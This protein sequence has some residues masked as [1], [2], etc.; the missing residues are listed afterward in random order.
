MGIRSKSMKFNAI[1]ILFLITFSLLIPFLP[2]TFLPNQSGI[3]NDKI[4]ED[5]FILESLSTEDIIYSGV[6]NEISGYSHYERTGTINNLDSTKDLEFFSNNWN[7][8]YTNFTL[9]NITALDQYVLIQTFTGSD[10]FFANTNGSTYYMEFKVSNSSYIDK[11][12]LHAKGN[13]T[14]TSLSI[15][16]AT[17]DSG[18]KPDELIYKQEISTPSSPI[19]IGQWLSYDIPYVELDTSLTFN[20]TYYIAINSTTQLFGQGFLWEYY[21]DSKDGDQGAAFYSTDQSS[22]SLQN[23]DFISNV[24]IKPLSYYPDP[25]NIE[26]NINNMLVNFTEAP[27]LVKN[28]LNFSYFEVADGIDVGSFSTYYNVSPSD[29]N[30]YTQIDYYINLNELGAHYSQISLLNLTFGV[31]LNFTNVNLTQAN[32]SIYD[33][34]DFIVGTMIGGF[35]TTDPSNS[36]QIILDSSNISN[37]VNKSSFIKVSFNASSE[38]QNY[39]ICMHEISVSINYQPSYGNWA[40]NNGVGN[41]LPINSTHT[42]Y[43]ISTNWPVE[44]N[45][46]YDLNF[47]KN[48]QLIPEFEAN[49]SDELVDW[50]VTLSNFQFNEYASNKQINFTIPA[51]WNVSNLYNNSLVLNE[52][53][54][55]NQTSGLNKIVSIL[56][57]TNSTYRIN[58]KS[59]NY[60]QSI[61]IPATAEITSLVN[62]TVTLKNS[63]SGSNLGLLTFYLDTYYAYNKTASA[64]GALIS[65]EGWYINDPA[66]N[67]TVTCKWKNGTEVGVKR[68]YININ[69]PEGAVWGNGD[70]RNYIAKSI[71]GNSGS[72]NQDYL[73]LN[74]ETWDILSPNM[75]IENLTAYNYSKIIEQDFYGISLSLSDTPAMSFNVTDNFTISTIKIEAANPAPFFIGIW[76]STGSIDNPIPHKLLKYY[77]PNTFENNSDWRTFKLTENNSINI[78]SDLTINDGTYYTYFIGINATSGNWKGSQ[79]TYDGTDDGKDYSIDL[80]TSFGIDLTLIMEFNPQDYT[81]TPVDIGLKINNQAIQNDNYWENNSRFNASGSIVQFNVASNWKNISFDVNWNGTLILN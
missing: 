11:I 65:F 44:F 29:L 53:Y 46:I 25:E 32:Y 60:V 63:I 14:Q 6:G 40:P 16:N 37:Y 36:V 80:S 28:N 17:D 49:S 75:T 52:M 54:W 18:A 39:S 7:V 55:V 43:N 50:N 71:A 24:S 1:F 45:L 79:H 23:I 10:N 47:R 57:A 59:N 66:G 42:V 3:E 27:A 67:Y 21:T 69:F 9:T 22:F 78:K 38:L 41:W 81:P 74:L 62:P 13:W 35:N 8:T 77:I 2:T 31:F 19:S 5:P 73:N 20:K 30:N 56:S 26:L 15:W 34:D 64:S 33:K 76:N 58:A 51:S 4:L 72:G 68:A 12:Y 48:F 61:N 70:G